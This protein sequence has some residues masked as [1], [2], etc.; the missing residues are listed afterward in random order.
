M[1]NG[2]GLR[3]GRTEDALVALE[4]L[5]EQRLSSSS[6]PCASY[7]RASTAIYSGGNHLRNA[8]AAG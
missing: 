8:V 7:T 5:L 6:S 3:S 1:R 2:S 4:K